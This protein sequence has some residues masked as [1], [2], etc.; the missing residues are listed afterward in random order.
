LKNPSKLIIIFT[1]LL[2]SGILWAQSTNLTY[3]GRL[4]QFG[5]PFSGNANL[6]FFLFDSA[7]VLRG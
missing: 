4:Q 3:Q 2:G 6:K 5:E 1:V 7:N